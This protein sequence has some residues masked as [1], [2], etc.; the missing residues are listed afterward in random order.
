P[1]IQ[2]GDARAVDRRQRVRGTADC[3]GARGYRERARA[4]GAETMIALADGLSYIDLQ[5]MGV[6]HAIA[7]AVLHRT[8]EVVLIDPGP[9]STMGTLRAS[10]EQSGIR[11]S[12]V[13]SL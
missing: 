11:I 8:G 1:R 13:T 6:P 9:S 4:T 3:V 2:L 10:L 7:T 12:D 5:F